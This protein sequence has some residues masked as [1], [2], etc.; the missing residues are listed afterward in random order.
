MGNE[1]VFAESNSMKPGKYMIID[2]LPCKVVNVDTSRPGKHGHAKL[3]ITAIDIFTGQKK[4]W[5]GASGH[6]IE[7]PIITRSSA[8]IV[9]VNDD[10][11]QLMD[12]TTYEVF[13]IKLT[14]EFRAEAEAGK[15]IELLEALGTKAIQRIKS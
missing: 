10:S 8:Q 7:V 1:K 12:S 9:A 13:E 15:E 3:R 4:Q 2:G 14:E 6:D 5:L 11:L